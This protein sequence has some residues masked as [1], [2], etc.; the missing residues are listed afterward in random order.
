MRNDLRFDFKKFFI[1]FLS[2][3][4]IFSVTIISNSHDSRTSSGNSSSIRSPSSSVG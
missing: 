3:L 4:D 1:A 2:N